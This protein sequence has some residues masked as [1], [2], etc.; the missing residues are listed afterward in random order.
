VQQHNISTR[1]KEFLADMSLPLSICQLVGDLLEAK[2]DEFV[3]DTVVS[4]PAVAEFDLMRMKAY[5]ESFLYDRT[6]PKKALDDTG[7][8]STVDTELHLYGR[9]E[10]IA[11]LRNVI[12]RVHMHA[13]NGQGNQGVRCEAVFLCGHSGSGKSSLIRHVLSSC[14]VSNN[15]F[16]VS[17]KFDRQISPLM[18]MAS[19]FD[20]FFGRLVPDRLQAD[21]RLQ[22]SLQRI[23][24]AIITSIDNEGF[25]Q[26][27]ELIPNLSNMIPSFALKAKK[28][29]S[30][31]QGMLLTKLSNTEKVGSAINRL[32]F[33]FQIL[34][35]SLC[36]HQPLLIV[37][38]DL[39]WA[40]AQVVQI[41]GGILE[42]MSETQSISSVSSQGGLLVMGSY[43]DNEVE[44]DG[45]L[46]KQ[47]QDLEQIQGNIVATWLSVDELSEHDINS[48]LSFKLCL[49]MRLTIQLAEIVHKK[50][51]GNPYYVKEFFR[52]IVSNKMLEFSVKE[53][54][55]I[56]D[57][58]VIDLQM[59]SEGVAEL[60]VRNL[61][62][63][64][65]TVLLTLK[66]LSCFGFQVSASMIALLSTNG[67]SFNLVEALEL[68]VKEGLVEHAG[69]MF[70]FT[71]DALQEACYALIPE[72]GRKRLHK[73]IGTTLIKYADNDQAL[74]L[75]A[76][77][78]VNM[79]KD[80]GLL[81]PEE[82]YLF[83]RHN[84]EAGKQSIVASNFA[85]ARGYFEAGISMLNEEHW[86]TQ[87]KLSLELYQRS[88]VVSF[89]DANMENVSA[90]LNEILSHA[91]SFEDTLQARALLSKQL[92]SMGQYTE[93]ISHC[94]GVLNDLGEKF[95]EEANVSN[96]LQELDNTRT[97][98]KDMTKEQFTILSSMTDETKLNA[99]RFLALTCTFAH[100]SQPTT[101]PLFS[102]RM[103][104]L[105]VEFGFCDDSIIGLAMTGFSMIS[106]FNAIEE[107]YRVGRIASL[108]TQDSTNKH[109][110]R[111]KL[112]TVLESHS[113]NY[114]EPMQ[115]VRAEF[116][117][118]YNSGMLVGD[119]ESALNAAA[120]FCCAGIHQ[121]A[122]MSG[123]GES[124][125]WLLQQMQQKQNTPLFYMS[126]CSL[127]SYI[128]LAGRN[129]LKNAELF[130]LKSF[131]ELRDI[132]TKTKNVLLTW[133]I[134]IELC[135]INL[136]LKKYTIVD[137]ISKNYRSTPS[138]RAL[139]AMRVFFDGISCLLLARQT[140][141]AKYRIVGEQAIE[142]MTIWVK[143]SKWNF[144]NK[145]R[146][147]QA[148]LHYLNEELEQAVTAYT[149][150]INSARQ[151]KFIHEEALAFELYGTFLVETKELDRGYAQLEVS[152]Q[153][154]IEWGA[155]KK[156]DDLRKFMKVV[157]PAELREIGAVQ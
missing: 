152:L 121:G 71:H 141:Q 107:G 98:L 82:R 19:S 26:L 1:A 14:N 106:M 21:S 116:L 28:S 91:T 63:L 73:K 140:N 147:L 75:V 72:S 127:H 157:F 135:C 136:Y 114:V 100:V 4:S 84:L 83:A 41:I 2:N 144:E 146:L 62:Q 30:E 122:E 87:Y 34:V 110:L 85:Q 125:S 108:L 45:L 12:D 70:S 59:I 119:V 89:M 49:P 46:L 92:A 68:A 129:P 40:D 120:S 22:Q 11:N 131:D 17:C 94:R 18:T 31:R 115:S 145:L 15:W 79:C 50:T 112:G 151:H 137:E 104:K 37:L 97:L 54:R 25:D 69:G 51:R 74:T 58:D 43:R 53:R 61:H 132:G 65:Q 20:A 139:E 142:T 24:Q 52:T 29:Y 7:I 128:A 93:A 88:V 64:S 16:L 78:Q 77:D 154:Y 109:A 32:L 81:C 133:L 150:A 102:C 5:P 90:R 27:C 35:K 153:K 67:F 6:D 13:S 118:V 80:D 101:L 155:F 9:D 48:L 33:L 143:Y 44:K 36:G 47:L 8:F 117:H 103:V 113:R 60:L 66:I 148:E 149:A 138:K 134:D 130:D 124:F 55:W 39:Q 57:N 10:S 105:T 95:G 76:V 96:A 23:S 56:W 86:T 123:L 42:T 111:A 3:S 126:L 156:A 99:M 38:D